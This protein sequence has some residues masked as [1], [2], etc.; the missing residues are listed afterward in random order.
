MEDVMRPLR[1]DLAAL[2]DYPG[3]S[4]RKN[5]WEK[6]RA[7]TRI[8]KAVEVLEELGIIDKKGRRFHKELPPDM[9]PDSK[10]DV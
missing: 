2:E 10:T 7:G 5:S 3:T 9:R 4:E 1:V 8:K 6:P